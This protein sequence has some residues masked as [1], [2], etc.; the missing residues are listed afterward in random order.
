LFENILI[1]DRYSQ[2]Q[3]MSVGAKRRHSSSRYN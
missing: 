1:G 3:K 2:N